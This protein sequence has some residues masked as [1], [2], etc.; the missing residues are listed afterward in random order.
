MYKRQLSYFAIIV[1]AI[2]ETSLEIVLDGQGLGPDDVDL[3]GMS[4]SVP[5]C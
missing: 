5:R 1:E 3:N 2:D 4:F